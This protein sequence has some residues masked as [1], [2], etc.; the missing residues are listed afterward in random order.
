[1]ASGRL[2]ARLRLELGAQLHEVQDSM[3]HADPS[4]E[5]NPTHLVATALV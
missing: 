3:G 2:I 5:R 4:L 1:M